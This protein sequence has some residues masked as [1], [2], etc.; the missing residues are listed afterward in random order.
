M[1][2]LHMSQSPQYVHVFMFVRVKQVGDH[3]PIVRS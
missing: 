1:R 2:T 3:Q